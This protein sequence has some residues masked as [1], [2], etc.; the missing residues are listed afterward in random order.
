MIPGIFGYDLESISH[1]KEKLPPSIGF[2]LDTGHAFISGALSQMV[3]VMDGKLFHLHLQDTCNGE[4]AHLLPGEGCINWEKFRKDMEKI[5]YQ[6]V[7]MLEVRERKDRG[8]EELLLSA[9]EAIEKLRT[10]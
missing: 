10:V 9:R 1:M 5:G 7:W 4:D 8:L 3:E 2:C 6:G